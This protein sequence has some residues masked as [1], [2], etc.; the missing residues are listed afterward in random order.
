MLQW[1]S[2]I[3]NLQLN[4]LTNIARLLIYAASWLPHGFWPVDQAHRAGSALRFYGIVNI[5][6]K[7]SPRNKSAYRP[8]TLRESDRYA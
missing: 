2:K 5:S 7:I 1:F 6:P 8:S 4:M 3:Y